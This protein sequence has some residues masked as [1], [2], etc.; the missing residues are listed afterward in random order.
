MDTVIYFLL[1]LGYLILIGIGIF[2]ANRDRWISL[3]NIILLVMLALLYDNGIL[4]VG[5]F[6][7]EGELLK[8]LNQM[9]YWLHA[10]VTPLLVLFAW[11]TLVNANIQWT[12]RKTVLW[13]IILLTIFFII[14]EIST[15]VQSP[16]LKPTW[17]NGVLSYKN[18]VEIEGLPIMV[19]GV[20]IILLVTSIMIWRKQN[21]PWYFVGFLSMG[22]VPIINFLFHMDL[23]HNIS[24]FLLMIALLA[25]KG[26]QN[27]QLQK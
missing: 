6:I 5:K 10:I 27:R 3:D 26:Y 8:I 20:S 25:T 18:A 13:A 17:H 19:I 2:L 21:W 22:M 14:S 23:P 24:E 1:S 9:R 15:L 16:P 4:A 11:K 7:G 12:K